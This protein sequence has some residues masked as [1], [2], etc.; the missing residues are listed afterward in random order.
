MGELT[1]DLWED[2]LRKGTA[3]LV[4]SNVDT[5]IVGHDCICAELLIVDL[6]WQLRVRGWWVLET[7]CVVGGNTVDV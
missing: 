3:L 2:E 5:T 4:Y 1:L 6:S 7:R